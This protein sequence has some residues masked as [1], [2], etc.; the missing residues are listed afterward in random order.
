[1]EILLGAR[2]ATV[3]EWPQHAKRLPSVKKKFRNGLVQGTASKPAEITGSSRSQLLNML[4]KTGVVS[5]LMRHQIVRGG[6]KG[7][8]V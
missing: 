5:V 1:M 2:T 6:T 7:G 8:S 3:R 4:R